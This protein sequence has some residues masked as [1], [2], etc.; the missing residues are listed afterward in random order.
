MKRLLCSKTI[1]ACSAAQ[2]VPRWLTAH[3]C[4]RIPPCLPSIKIRQTEQHF[5]LIFFTSFLLFL[6]VGLTEDTLPCKCSFT[7]VTLQSFQPYSHVWPVTFIS[8]RKLAIYINYVKNVY[9][10]V[11]RPRGTHP[12]FP[13]LRTHRLCLYALK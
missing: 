2:S 1:T 11:Q 13:Q 4:Q 10:F 8:L 5:Y 9:I 7:Y 3:Q 6:N 12:D